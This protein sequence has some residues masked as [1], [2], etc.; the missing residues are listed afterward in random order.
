MKIFLLMLSFFLYNGI[1]Y[2][3]SSPTD[4]SD[5]DNATL[6]LSVKPSYYNPEGRLAG[7]CIMPFIEISIS[8]VR[9]LFAFSE[10][11]FYK[12]GKN[13]QEVPSH[14]KVKFYP[15]S[16]GAKF[17]PIMEDNFGLYLKGGPTIGFLSSS[18]SWPYLPNKDTTT[19][20]GGMVGF[21][22]LFQVDKNFGIDVFLNYLFCKKSF[23]DSISHMKLSVNGSGLVCGIGFGLL[24]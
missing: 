5:L 1:L 14:T 12:K 15:F 11:G 17:F 23:F 8:P 20:T 22:G 18:Q 7:D 16:F 19:I 4:I 13:V 10:I 6:F 2:S 21:G 9:R 3:W 24:Y